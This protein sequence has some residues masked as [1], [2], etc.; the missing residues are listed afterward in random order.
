MDTRTTT[1]AGALL[2]LVL[3]A[4]CAGENEAAKAA[5]D[6]CVEHEGD[7]DLMALDGSKVTI[8]V[9]GDNAKALSASGG[10]ADDILAGNELDDEG[11]SGVVVSMAVLMGAE[12]LAEES[13]FPGAPDELKDGD[14]WEGWEFAEMSGAGSSFTMTFTATS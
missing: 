3:L 1:I 2:A 5:Y 13:G 9:D 14:E 6:A 11:V 10:V 4:G 12:C 8:T 7:L